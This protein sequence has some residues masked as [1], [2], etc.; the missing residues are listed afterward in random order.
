MA[1]NI[2][3]SIP[4]T[5]LVLL[6]VSV[7]GQ[8]GGNSSAD[9]ALR[10][11]TSHTPSSQPRTQPT[12]QQVPTPKVEPSSV[13]QTVAAVASESSTPTEP[14]ESFSQ[15]TLFLFASGLGLFIAL[16]GWSDQIR[17]IDRDTR[18]L[19]ERFL[20]KTG[21]DRR[22][23]L[24]VVKPESAEDQLQVLTE[25]V[26]DG[27]L[28]TTAAAEVL[29]TFA[30]TWNTQW[31][32]IEKLSEWKYKL[33][34]VLTLLLFATGIASLFTTP[35]QKVPVVSVRAEMVLIILPMM[36]IG[37]LLIIIIC[38]ARQEK[39]LRTLLNSMSDMV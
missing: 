11:D 21:I 37:L 34:I 6:A 28:K 19:E 16:L 2:S 17:G 10:Q 27:R 5:A 31:A 13:N 38:S 36:L 18:E 29:R 9:G 26:Q 7:F 1:M 15:L 32:S 23:F 4:A 30:T 33:T 39:A 35:T 14:K 12:P 20:K 25:I 24:D 3:H 8:S 22:D